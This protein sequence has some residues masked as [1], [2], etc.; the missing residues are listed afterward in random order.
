[1][2]LLVPAGQDF[3]WYY[4]NTLT[5]RPNVTAF[6][7][8]ITPAVA[9]TFGAWTQVATAANIANDVYGVLICINNAATSAA[10]RNIL[11]DLGVDNAG[12]TTY[13]TKI[14]YLQ[15]GSAAPYGTSLGGIWYYFPLYINR[16]SSVAVRAMGTTTAAFN[17]SVY[18]YGQP[19]RP[20]AVRAGSYVDAYGFNTTGAL[21]TA[22]TPG[23]TAEGT[24]TQLGTTTS[25]YWWWQCGFNVN[26]TTMTAATIHA[27][28]S[29]GTAA[30]K[31]ILF[32]NQLWQTTAAEQTSCAINTANA[33]NNTASGDI[34]YGRLQHSSTA[35]TG[36]AMI[37]YGLGG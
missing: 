3:Q 14:P 4:S 32:E 1:M 27:D 15:G 18:F 36:N 8:S 16:G 28:L 11:M 29:A 35:D 17:C 5:T 24:W 6:G 37:A 30:Q 9:P 13:L 7:T 23:T 2:G 12:G 19:R 10:T 22:V 25:S 21:G 34:I 20:D 33:Y 26:D 31:K